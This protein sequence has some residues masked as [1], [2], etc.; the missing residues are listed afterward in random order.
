MMQMTKEQLERAISL[1]D[2]MYELD[3]DAYEMMTKLS[4]IQALADRLGRADVMENAGRLYDVL[5]ER[6]REGLRRSHSGK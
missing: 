3:P 6:M 4:I 5:E 1:N 2:E